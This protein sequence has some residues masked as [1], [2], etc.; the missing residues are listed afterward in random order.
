MVPIRNIAQLAMFA[1]RWTIRAHRYPPSDGKVEQPI[2]ILNEN[3]SE[4]P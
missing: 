4:S 3:Q 1:L 2:S